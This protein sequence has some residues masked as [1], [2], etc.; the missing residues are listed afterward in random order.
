MKGEHSP[1]DKHVKEKFSE[2]TWQGQSGLTV[3]GHRGGDIPYDPKVKEESTTPRE[4][5]P[6]GKSSMCKGLSQVGA[7]SICGTKRTI[8]LVAWV[9]RVKAKARDAEG[10]SKTRQ[11]LVHQRGVLHPSIRQ[12]M[13]S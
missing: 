10:R 5:I 11:D 4:R 6:S 3:A 7:W 2:D 9:V 8:W 12:A 13:K 1:T